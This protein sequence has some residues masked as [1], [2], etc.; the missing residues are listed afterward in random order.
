M[1]VHCTIL[2]K[3]FPVTYFCAF[4]FC[5]IYYSQFQKAVNVRRCCKSSLR[6]NFCV[7]FSR[8]RICA[9]IVPS[10]FTLII[11]TQK[12]KFSRWRWSEIAVTLRGSVCKLKLNTPM[13][14]LWQLYS[15]ASINQCHLLRLL[16]N[17]CVCL[18]VCVCVCDMQAPF[19]EKWCCRTVLTE[20]CRSTSER[21]LVG[22]ASVQTGTGAIWKRKWFVINSATKTARRSRTRTTRLG[23]SEHVL[24][25]MCKT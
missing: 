1:C 5:F 12:F 15:F 10:L 4:N 24:H 18:C 3:N 25:G 6:L 9:K 20:R 14:S 11:Y 17:M 7:H 23:E 19:M 2:P 13:R 16:V 21:A 8:N 22:P